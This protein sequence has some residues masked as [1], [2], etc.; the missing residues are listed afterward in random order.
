MTQK[1]DLIDLNTGINGPFDDGMKML[2]DH[3]LR[4][5]FKDVIFLEQHGML[6]IL[7]EEFRLM[8]KIIK[9][10][11]ANEEIHQS[12]IIKLIHVLDLIEE[13]YPS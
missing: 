2:R 5:G 12:H 8:P 4:L 9:D 13:S 10:K 6:T 1:P 3:I 11:N 7:C